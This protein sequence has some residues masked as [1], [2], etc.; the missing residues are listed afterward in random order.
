[1]AGKEL[2]VVIS[3][4]DDLSPKLKAL[5][6]AA[7]D[8][9]NALEKSGKEAGE[10]F[11]QVSEGAETAE[12]SM[13]QLSETG[14]GFI[15]TMDG[16]SGSISTLG[17]GFQSIGFALDGLGDSY[18]SQQQRL[19]T[20]Q[21]QYGE[22][23]GE[24]RQFS[25]E[26]QG[27]TLFSDDA[28]QQ[29]LVYFGSLVDQYGLTIEQVKQLSQVTADLAQANGIAYEDAALRVQAAVRGETEGAEILGLALNQQSIDRQNLT[30]TMSN[31]EAAQFRLNALMTQAAYA[32][33]SANA[34]VERSGGAW[35]QF[36]NEVQDAGQAAGQFVGPAGDMLSTLG[37]GLAT[38]GEATRGITDLKTGMN[39]LIGIAQKSTLV[40][41]AFELATGPVGWAILGVTAAIGAG[42]YVWHQQQEDVKAAQEAY[43]AYG[44]AVQTVDD[45]IANERLNGDDAL[46]GRMETTAKAIRDATAQ[47]VAGAQEEIERSK[48]T[49]EDLFDAD[50]DTVRANVT[51]FLSDGVGKAA[52][53]WAKSNGTSQEVIDI[54][55]TGAYEGAAQAQALLEPIM[56]DYW[57]HIT[58]SDADAAKIVAEISK[59][60]ELMAN[61][62][63][64]QSALTAGVQKIYADLARTGDVDAAVA[65]FEALW[66]SLESG[67]S[68]AN[69]LHASLRQVSD[70]MGG[71]LTSSID[72]T[73]QALAD[74]SK[75]ATV[76]GDAYAE[77]YRAQNGKYPV[78]DETRRQNDLLREQARLAGLLQAELAK[79]SYAD[80]AKVAEY[81][82]A[83]EG[84]NDALA[85]QARAERE[86]AQA[87]RQYAA[88]AATDRE[89]DRQDRKAAWE[90]EKAEY[91][92]RRAAA[93]EQA[94]AEHQ[95]AV[96]AA[97]QRKQ[98]SDD[99][100][101]AWE[102][103]RERQRQIVEERKQA[104]QEMIAGYLDATGDG[105]FVS[106]LNLGGIG[107]QYS[108]LAENI[109]D[110][111]TALA[112]GY[113]VIV[114]G[115]DAIAQQS[116]TVADWADKMIG[117]AGTTAVLDEAYARWVE[118]A[119][120]DQ[121]KINAAW[122]HYNDI[123][124]DGTR[125]L[126]ANAA[127]Q[128]DI[129]DIQLNQSGV[130][131][132]LTEQ[133]A[134]YIDQ[135]AGLPADQQLI[136]LGWMD[137]TEAAKA[138]QAVTM[139]A[140]AANGELGSSGKDA[141][142]KMIAAQAQADPILKDMLLDIGLIDEKIGANGERVITV[143]FDQAKGAS[144]S[145][146]ELTKSIDALTLALGGV[147]PL[148]VDAD[149]GYAQSQI[150][151]VRD[152][153]NGLGDDAGAAG[154][155][156]DTLNGRLVE[157]AH[158]HAEPAVDVE[159]GDA[160]GAIQSVRD[161]LDPL[162]GKTFEAR[163]RVLLD[164]ETG[165]GEGG[166]LG[167]RIGSIA[168]RFGGDG[169]GVKI[170][171]SYDA[172]PPLELPEPEP[173]KVPVKYDMSR[174]DAQGPSSLPDG[175]T[176]ITITVTADVAQAVVGLYN[177][178]TQVNTLN[179]SKAT[180]A[181]EATDNASGKISAASSALAHI[182]GQMS[183]MFVAADTSD[184]EAGI[185][186]AQGYNG[187][188]LATSYID[189]VTRTST[190][191][192]GGGS[193]L[194]E[195]HGGIPAYASGGVLFRGGEA[196]PELAHFAGGGT[197]LLP[198]DDLYIAPAG[199]VIEPAN[200]AATKLTPGYG[201]RGGPLVHIENITIGAG[202]DPGSAD[203][204]VRE[205]VTRLDRA[206][207]HRDRSGGLVA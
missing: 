192:Y 19:D 151:A 38:V 185:G 31:Q 20:L 121:D 141:V 84:V 177:V 52:I 150:D 207:E 186:W 191:N 17:A 3:G 187:T 136:T 28:I 14:S 13:M 91:E 167:G 70:F 68:S 98:D 100:Q 122:E 11:E 170:P 206:L 133:Q 124:A 117:A 51:A 132:D 200:S 129:Q 168:S 40:M 173:V 45:A 90:D 59:M 204:I 112:D 66:T 47:G 188:V 165:G 172:P 15:R 79:G 63:I 154:T 35:R 75:Q 83:L 163:V 27:Q 58:P 43:E 130:L 127:I 55:T 138:N 93:K 134:D 26:M 69:N 148:H 174:F 125:I 34:A 12:K 39:G 193:G 176:D 110:A 164:D 86:V 57:S 85:Q 128:Q 60:F 116:Q 118:A 198:R 146:A 115:T 36:T 89:K 103:E 162:D 111:N 88:E 108:Q 81:E 61:P 97:N 178:Q 101:A 64:D 194:A 107:T 105:D 50:T 152:R 62:K 153:L 71:E 161:Q 166:G 4:Q 143:N 42:A 205:I 23:Y 169:G 30:L 203:A 76:T 195:R 16:M 2:K 92:E 113:R 131:A 67:A 179:G 199:T 180:V 5:A 22:F 106:Q 142:E 171:V 53:D 149:T 139:A 189:I 80:P 140:A 197:A 147:P 65:A 74:A 157:L 46:A 156:V 7:S 119:G 95:Y 82:G 56:Q 114:G 21:R 155:D 202:A 77:L 54:L 94:D 175:S 183:T 135:L 102:E 32:Q 24:L 126:T 190:V 37:G 158:Q 104:A 9:A 41:S 120:G 201:L 99:R 181:I 78:G 18:L 145:I 6:T 96:E 196:G 72:R 159:T 160:S 29:G 123:Q 25:E 49:W 109:N 33:G 144:D 87:R 44:K 182:E 137:A 1:M 73:N 10:S 184:A 8:F 48:I